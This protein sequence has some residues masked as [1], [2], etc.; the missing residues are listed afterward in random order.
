VEVP[1][2]TNSALDRWIKHSKAKATCSFKKDSR[3][4][5]KIKLISLRIENQRLLMENGMFKQ[6]ALILSSRV[7]VIALVN[8]TCSV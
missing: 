1:D 4:F 2:L 8:D 5:K 7:T 6:V 3:S